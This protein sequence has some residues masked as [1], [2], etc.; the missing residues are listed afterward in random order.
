MTLSSDCSVQPTL[1]AD[2]IHDFQASLTVIRG[3]AQLI[4]RKMQRSTC[5]DAAQLLARLDVINRVATQLSVE[6]EKLRQPE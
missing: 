1:R 6:I 3:Q 2:T 4:Q 5:A